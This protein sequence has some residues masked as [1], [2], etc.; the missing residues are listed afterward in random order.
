MKI[1]R[2]GVVKPSASTNTAAYTV[3]AANTASW[4]VMVCNIGE[5]SAKIRL[6]IVDGA[7]AALA[8]EDYI[9][10]GVDIPAGSAYPGHTVRPASCSAGRFPNRAME[11]LAMVVS[12]AQ[13]RCDDPGWIAGEPTTDRAGDRRLVHEPEA[14][15]DG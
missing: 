11:Y 2:L 8:E 10:Y 1:G 12:S 3:P 5:Y 15:V 9:E 13:R 14:G 7:A 4:S 6:A